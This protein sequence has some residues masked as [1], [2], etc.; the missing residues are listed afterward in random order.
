M[1]N[2]VLWFM[3]KLPYWPLVEEN[4]YDSLVLKFLASLFS[5]SPAL[6]ST[7]HTWCYI[8]WWNSVDKYMERKKY[9]GINFPSF[10]WDKISVIDNLIFKLL[11][12]IHF[13]L[14]SSRFLYFQCIF[15]CLYGWLIAMRSTGML[16]KL[17]FVVWHYKLRVYML[18]HRDVIWYQ[19]HILNLL[20]G[21]PFVNKFITLWIIN[22]DDDSRLYCNLCLT[23]LR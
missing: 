2:L 12:M 16:S 7:W 9:Q 5:M 21:D 8:V 18:Y 14:L 10:A 3:W 20:W 13:S 19:L 1:D 4:V 15:F 11:A 17:Y 23:F 6:L 22:I